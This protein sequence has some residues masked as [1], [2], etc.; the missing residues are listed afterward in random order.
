ML[1]VYKSAID[2]QIEVDSVD[3]L[4]H[5]PLGEVMRLI[6]TGELRSYQVRWCCCGKQWFE[7]GEMPA[8]HESDDV[9]VE[10]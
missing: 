6:E 5:H 9:W 10:A 2:K 1:Q 4:A 3:K 7:K 8:T